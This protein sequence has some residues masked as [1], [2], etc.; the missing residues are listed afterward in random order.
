MKN[1]DWFEEYK[2][3]HPELVTEVEF[4]IPLDM[5]QKLLRTLDFDDL[6]KNYE[7]CLNNQYFE[8][9]IYVQKECDRRGIKVSITGDIN[10]TRGKYKLIKN[11]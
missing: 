3:L 5:Y 10:N 9:L 6:G 7:L 1:W 8:N 4:E 2:A 11:E